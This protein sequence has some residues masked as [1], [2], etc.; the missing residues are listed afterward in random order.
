[1][2]LL[3]AAVLAFGAWRLAAP[4]ADDAGDEVGA[5]VTGVV[6]RADDARFDVAAA[7]LELQR[8]S[9][10]SYAGASVPEGVL[11]VRAD[12]TGYCVEL[13]G[14]NPPRHLAGPGAVPAVGRC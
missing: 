1:A 14:A 12:T 7:N 6:Q 10:A 5:A 9:T 11:L 13:A 4:A 8:R 3:A 2:L